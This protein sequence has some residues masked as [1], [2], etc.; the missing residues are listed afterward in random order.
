MCVFKWKLRNTYGIKNRDIK[1]IHDDEVN[2]IAEYN[3]LHDIINPPKHNKVLDSHYSPIL[4][5][6]MNKRKGRA[7]FKN[8]ESYWTVDVVPKLYWEG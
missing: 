7:N 1:R 2:N 4:H 6:C 8:F 5:G 3:L